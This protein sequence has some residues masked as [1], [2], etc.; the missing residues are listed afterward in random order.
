M[1]KMVASTTE[2]ANGEKIRSKRLLIVV[3]KKKRV[4]NLI[5]MKTFQNLKFKICP[6]EKQHV[7][8]SYRKQGVITN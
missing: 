6:H 3:D 8:W 4:E 1:I 7:K 5:K 2:N